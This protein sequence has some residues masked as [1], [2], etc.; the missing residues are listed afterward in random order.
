LLD[1]PVLL[2]H[3]ENADVTAGER[4][5]RIVKRHQAQNIDG[6]VAIAMA[7]YGATAEQQVSS[8]FER[9]RNIRSLMKAA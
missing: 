8:K 3:F 5:W 7:V 6:V 9:H 1:D 2:A 4:G